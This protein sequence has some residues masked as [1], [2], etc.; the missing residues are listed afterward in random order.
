MKYSADNVPLSEVKKFLSDRGYNVKDLDDD[1]IQIAKEE[2]A[3]TLNGEP[4]LGG[5]FEFPPMLSLKL[6]PR[7]DDTDD[8][9]EITPGVV[10]MKTTDIPEDIDI[11]FDSPL[12]TKDNSLYLTIRQKPFDEIVAGTKTIEYRTVSE[13]TFKNYIRVDE[14]GYPFLLEGAQEPEIPELDLLLYND[15]VCPFWLR[16][17]ICFLRLKAGATAKDMDSAVVEVKSMTMAP[18]ER[19]RYDVAHDAMI[20]NPEGRYC[21][22]IAE[23]HLGKVRSLYRKK[24]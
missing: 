24:R 21:M 3:M 16:D 19:F 8:T 6:E 11:P 20:P 4:F 23:L 22:W 12:L 18:G 5:P 7:P 15:G 9:V 2:T 14:D 10:D 1:L 13:N 17:D